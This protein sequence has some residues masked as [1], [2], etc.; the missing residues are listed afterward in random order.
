RDIREQVGKAAAILG[1]EPYLDRKPRE[2]SGGQMQR[3]AMGRAIV[4]NPEI[5]LFDEPLSNLDAKLRVKVRGEIKALHQRLKTTTVY[6]T[7]DQVEA[8]TLADRLV[9]MNQGNVE[10]IGTPLELYD[11]PATDFVAGFIGTPPMNLFEGRLQA[12]EKP[13]FVLED[14]TSLPLPDRFGSVEPGAGRI[15][16]GVRPEHLVSAGSGWELTVDLVETMGNETHITGHIG[17]SE[18]IFVMT[19]R[20]F[21]APG[22]KVHLSPEDDSLHLF[23]D[24]KRL[25]MDA[26]PSTDGAN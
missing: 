10:Q 20:N 2:L 3:V 17:A 18:A 15:T 12:G 5:F 22:D 16:L 13:C 11:R 6:V 8:M 9:V 19:G 25:D 7:H 14:G 4:R 26:A 24:G 23:V 21:P 1:L